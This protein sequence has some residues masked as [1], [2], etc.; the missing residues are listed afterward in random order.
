MSLPA[1]DVRAASSE[2]GRSFAFA[3]EKGEIHLLLERATE[4]PRISVPQPLLAL[5]FSRDGARLGTL[6]RT[7]TVRIY[8][9]RRDGG[10]SRRSTF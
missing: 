6:D 9:L 2:D 8:G 5:A 3:T 10:F 7:G 4:P 1:K